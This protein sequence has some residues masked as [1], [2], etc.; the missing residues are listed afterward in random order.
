VFPLRYRQR[1]ASRFIIS[2]RHAA[3]L[4]LAFIANFHTPG[5][6]ILLYG[7]TIG[8]VIG[9]I[10]QGAIDGGYDY[11]VHSKLLIVTG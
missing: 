1:L 8:P 10:Q 11:Q 7:S 5:W 4:A 2:Q 3:A 9:R 6:I